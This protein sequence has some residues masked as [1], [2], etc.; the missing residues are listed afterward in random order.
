MKKILPQKFLL[1]LL[2]P[3]NFSPLTMEKSIMKPR[4]LFIVFLKIFN[5]PILYSFQK[6]YHVSDTGVGPYHPRE[7]EVDIKAYYQWVPFMLF[8]QGML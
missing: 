4:L 3:G 8:L 2:R 7:D 1:R 5:D 6:G